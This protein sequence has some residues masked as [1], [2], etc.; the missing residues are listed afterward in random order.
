MTRGKA[1]DARI[2]GIEHGDTVGRQTIDQ[3]PLGG[4][5]AFDG[6]EELHVRIA[7]VG[8]H[9]DVRFGDLRESADFSGVVHAHLDDTGAAGIRQAQQGKRHAHVVVEIAVRLAGR[10]LAFQQVRDGVLSGGL[11]GAAGHADHP[12]TPPLACP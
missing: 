7:N 6:I 12:A 4:G 11:A 1:G 10:Q 3:F 8:H 5:N 9:A 2:V